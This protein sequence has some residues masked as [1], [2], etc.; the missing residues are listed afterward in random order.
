MDGNYIRGN[1]DAIILKCL[2][3]GELYGTQICNL[4]HAASEG[5]Y[6]LKK[7]TLYSALKRLQADKLVSIR[8]EES[9]IGGT[10]HYYTLTDA[11][12]EYL[13]DKKFD[14]VY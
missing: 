3:G 14:W 8:I 4:I 9:P 5:T 6:T 2:S 10:R 1:V 7:P 12:R 11:G 13:T